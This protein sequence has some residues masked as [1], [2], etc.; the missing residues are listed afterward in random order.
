MVRCWSV[1]GC[2]TSALNCWGLLFSELRWIALP[3]LL[4]TL[5]PWWVAF[6]F[7][8]KYYRRVGGSTVLAADEELVDVGQLFLFFPV[9]GRFYLTCRVFHVG[10]L[11]WPCHPLHCP[12]CFLVLLPDFLL[13]SSPTLDGLP[14]I[15]CDSLLPRLLFASSSPVCV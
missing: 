10:L 13:Q 9:G 6:L 2:C 14:G 4:P 1:S 12:V 8:H 11:V 15:C 3:I 7:I 5:L